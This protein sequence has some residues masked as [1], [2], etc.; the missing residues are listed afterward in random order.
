MKIKHIIP[1]FI[2]TGLLQV[3]CKKDTG[4]T[5]TSASLNIVNAAIDASPIVVNYASLPLVWSKNTTQI[6][7]NSFVEFGLSQGSNQLNLISSA[8]TTKP[9]FQGKLNL[10]TGGIYSLYI[11]GQVLHYDTLFMKDNIPYYAADSVAGAR[12][13]NLAS[14]SQ[15]LS[16]NLVGNATPD[17]SSIA[18]KKITA[19][20]KYPATMEVINN[21]G[22][23]YEIRDA[24]GNV[25]T[26]FNWNPATFK[27][28]TLVISGLV[29]DSS[30]SVFA[31]NNY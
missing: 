5:S 22:Y 10:V 18:Y 21:G 3:S 9:F 29:S 25:L 6:Y 8:D 19:F 2:L 23:T 16:I 30:I 26:T 12:F 4:I 20:K 31:V 11:A 7:N 17:F 24:L 13:I 27:N 14:D 15:P 1:I 28:N